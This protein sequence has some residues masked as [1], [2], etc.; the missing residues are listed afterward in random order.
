MQLPVLN[1]TQKQEYKRKQMDWHDSH[2]KTYKPPLLRAGETEVFYRTFEHQVASTLLKDSGFA[3][4]NERMRALFSCVGCGEGMPFW[5]NRFPIKEF[6]AI[7]LSLEACRL[8]R[9]VTRG[10]VERSRFIQADAES[11]P[12]PDESFDLAIVHNGLHHLTDPAAGLRELWR[13]SRGA[14][15]VIEPADC[16]LM[17]LFIRLGVARSREDSGNEVVRFRKKDY[18]SFLELSGTPQIHYRRYFWYEHPFLCDRLLP[19]LNHSAGRML[20][21]ILLSV[22]DHVF[23]FFRTKSAA[24]ILKS[25]RHIRQVRKGRVVQGHCWT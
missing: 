20:T 24:V 4:G 6:V 22:F 23:F 15:I 12:F 8:A 10:Q 21:R 7:D 9:E 16:L 17:P 11:L 2:Y 1:G 19:Q 5:L 18:L 13:V 14:V 3:P 25:R